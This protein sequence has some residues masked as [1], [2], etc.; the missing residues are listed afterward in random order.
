MARA[1]STRRR[2]AGP[3]GA[4]MPGRSRYRRVDRAAERGVERV[5]AR[6]RLVRGGRPGGGTPSAV[7]GS[8]ASRDDG[9][10][11]GHAYGS[12]ALRQLLNRRSWYG[13]S[14]SHSTTRIRSPP[15]QNRPNRP[16]GSVPRGGRC[17]PSPR[18]RGRS[19]PP[20][21]SCP[22]AMSTTPNH[23]TVVG[24]EA[25]EHQRA[26]AGLEHV[27]RQHP[28]PGRSTVP[29]G[30]IGK[31]LTRPSSRG[32][33]VRGELRCGRARRIRRQGVHEVAPRAAGSRSRP[34][35][36]Q[37]QRELDGGRLPR[38]ARTPTAS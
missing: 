38:P 30:N 22:R 2:S 19:S 11:R 16:S 5:A 29:S 32:R 13:S 33:S 1:A 8:H 28:S 31:V 15:T 21:T 3:S 17:V 37:E 18:G 36:V 10:Q 12:T 4:P 34:R 20:P 6:E 25:V 14:A 9:R 24:G 7:C 26:V 27:Q 35:R 23:G